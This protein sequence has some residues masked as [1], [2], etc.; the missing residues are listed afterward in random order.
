MKSGHSAQGLDILPEIEKEVKIRKSIQIV[1]KIVDIHS[2][3][4]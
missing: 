4:S 1:G 2:I 3:F